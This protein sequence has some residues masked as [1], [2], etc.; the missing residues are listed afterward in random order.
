MTLT[1]IRDLRVFVR[2]VFRE[3]T[4]KKRTFGPADDAKRLA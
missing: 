4:A 1:G 3:F 2:F